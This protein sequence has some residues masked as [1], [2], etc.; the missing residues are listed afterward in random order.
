MDA[1]TSYYLLH[2]E[3]YLPAS[4]AGSFEKKLVGFSMDSVA[5]SFFPNENIG[6]D[7]SLDESGLEG[8]NKNLGAAISSV[9]SSGFEAE[10]PENVEV[11]GAVFSNA[12]SFGGSFCTSG[13][14]FGGDGGGSFAVISSIGSILSSSFTSPV[15]T[16]STSA[17]VSVHDVPYFYN[18]AW[19]QNG[20]VNL[21]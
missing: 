11:A 17:S 14:D 10:N 8:L 7:L 18:K 6:G 13:S 1:K 4:P 21:K 12:N 2:K 16:V 3:A 5:G 9:E 20:S 15:S 19:Y